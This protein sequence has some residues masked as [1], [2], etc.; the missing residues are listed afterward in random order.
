MFEF[1]ALTRLAL[2]RHRGMLCYAILYFAVLL[3]GAFLYGTWGVVAEPQPGATVAAISLIGSL[4]LLL[5]AFAMFDFSDQADIGTP[6]SGYLPWLLRTPIKSWKLALVPIGLKTAWVLAICFA[7]ATMCRV[8]GYPVARWLLPGI[9]LTSLAVIALATVWSPVRRR[10][11]RILIAMVSVV[12]F[13]AWFVTCVLF[14]FDAEG[15]IFDELSLD[16]RSGLLASWI[17][18]VG[19]YLSATAFAIRGVGLARHN[20]S[21][22]IAEQRDRM[23]GQVPFASSQRDTVELPERTG[24][25]FTMAGVSSIRALFRYERSKLSQP[26]ARLVMIGWLATVVFCSFLDASDAAAVVLLF[27]CVLF[28][29]LFLT[30]WMVGC[31]RTFLPNTL[32]FAPIRSCTLVWTRQCITTLIW[33]T[34]LLGFLIAWSMWEIRGVTDRILDQWNHAAEH[35][36]GITNGGSSAASAI[37]LLTLIATL[38]HATWTV[39]VEATGRRRYKLYGIL[40][41]FA[42]GTALLGW[43]L[44]HF[45]RFPDW[46]AWTDWLIQWGETL[47]R[48]LLAVVLLRAVLITGSTVWLRRSNL[49]SR[50]ELAGLLLGYGVVVA[51][52]SIVLSQ[53]LQ[54]SAIRWWHCTAI[55]AAITPF[56]RI[57]LAPIALASFRHRH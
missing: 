54:G 26:V 20:V 50:G 41:K 37:G 3:I 31:D 1:L 19:I 40:A 53:L 23:Q 42:L 56:C 35:V 5:I 14:A 32:A 36:L 33:S 49:V 46:Q 9:G 11:S 44:S 39:T 17:L 7:V 2:A 21:G 12:P 25:H 38:R 10:H 47:S 30:E 8:F 34:S 52:F 6:S 27:V 43:F 24:A 18:G 48:P 29:G 55:I 15:Q 28:P 51:A 45:L 57:A 4:P 22:R 13:Y 16:H